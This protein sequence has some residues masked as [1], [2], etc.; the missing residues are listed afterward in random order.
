M[1]MKAGKPH[2]YCLQATD[3]ESLFAGGIQSK[4]G[5][6][7]TWGAGGVNPNPRAGNDEVGC[8]S[9]SRWAVREKANSSL[10][11]LLFYSSP[12]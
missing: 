10:L 4:S 1:I 12:Q 2:V 3:P 6:L 9:S 11:H 7:R 8:P 5:G